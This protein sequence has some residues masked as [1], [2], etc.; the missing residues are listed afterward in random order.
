[1]RLKTSKHS[2]GPG[3]S[4][5]LIA[6]DMGNTTTSYAI[7]KNRQIL[8]FGSVKTVNIPK[9][10]H[11]L[12]ISGKYNAIHT[13][14]CSV[15]PKKCHILAKHI[16]KNHQ[17]KLYIVGKELKLNTPSAY[18]PKALGLDR[19]VNV[20]GGLK[21]YRKPM[22]II[23]F[24][25]AITF[26][27]VSKRGRFEGGLIVPGVETSAEALSAKAALIP[28][29]KG[30]KHVRN[31]LGRDTDEAF[32]SGLLNGFGALADGLVERFKQ[33]FGRNMT[34]VA[35]GGFSKR[36]SAYAKSFDYVDPLHT[37]KSLAQIYRNKIEDKP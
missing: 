27:Y 33:R 11:F 34:V 35:T 14:I 32:Q 28:K 13:V 16:S 4:S 20:Y 2:M 24:G 10:C 31:L 17:I 5:L 9:N 1:M 36:I 6:I 22:L 26:D 7:F 3:K 23:D 19:L 12:N 18:N 21:F 37:L 29:L 25:T 8:D 30:I 15:V